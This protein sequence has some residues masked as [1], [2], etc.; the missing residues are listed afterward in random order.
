MKKIFYAMF[1]LMVG[2]LFFTSCNDE[3]DEYS[4]Y[5]AVGDIVPGTNKQFIVMDDCDTILITNKE[6]L[7]NVD[8]SRIMMLIEIIS[9]KKSGEFNFY[10][11]RVVDFQKVLTKNP[12]LTSYIAQDEEHRKDSIGND[13]I[14]IYKA[15]IESNY[16]N[17]IYTIHTGESSVSHFI[18]LVIDDSKDFVIENGEL[19]LNA[20]MCHNAHG[21]LQMYRNHGYVSFKMEN[22]LNME[23]VNKITVNI[24]NGE[25]DIKVVKWEKKTVVPDATLKTGNILGIDY[26]KS[27]N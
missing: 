1:A 24:K 5:Q 3:N 15:E 11:A 26:L 17:V 12:V 23:N 9:E 10:E 13:Y 2:S 22:Y 21:D 18:N 27:T 25:N 4:I 19:I 16:L 8:Y 20:E 7:N 6:K 14:S